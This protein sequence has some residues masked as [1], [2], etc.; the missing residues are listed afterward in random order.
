MKKRIIALLCLLAMAV[1][2]VATGCQ[3]KVVAYKRGEPLPVNRINF[4]GLD[5]NEFY[6]AG[7][8]GPQNFYAAVG[9]ALPS[10]LTDE[11]YAKLAE[12]GIN[13]IIEQR[14]DVEESPEAVKALELAEKYNINYFMKVE[15][16]FKTEVSSPADG[17]IAEKE[18]IKTKLEELLKYD[19]FGGVYFRDEPCSDLFPFL[20]DAVDVLYEVREELDDTTLNAYI[21]GFPMIGWSGLSNG[22]DPEM[23]WEKY[24][25]GI[26]ETGVDYLSWDAYPF[27]N[28]PGE[29]QAT[30]LNALGTMKEIGDR[31]NLPIIGNVQCGGYLP[32]F[33]TSH[34]VVNE[35]EM[36]WNVGTM[37]AF[38]FKGITYYTLVTPPEGALEGEEYVNND[39]ILNK[40]GTKTPFW[41]YAKSINEQIQAMA[42]VLLNATQEGVMLDNNDS[43]NIYTGKDILDSYR[44]LKGWSGDSA[45]IGCFDYEGTV[46]LVVVNNSLE[47]RHAVV[48]LEFDNNYEYEVTQRATIDTISG[49]EFSLHLDSGEFALV[50]V[51]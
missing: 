18:T 49:K 33:S 48:T 41:H 35:A 31:Y 16:V 43:P 12:A 27:T 38:G 40:Y 25:E 5:E 32:F 8:I 7:Y 3:G 6:I 50:V 14:M 24:L 44:C 42:P 47:N 39:S 15:S 20:T 21:N 36:N 19:S 4:R 10:L 23:T 11:V 1:S 28:V 9:Y 2:L 46:A 26:C 13:Y 51:K 29:V 30:W 17:Y 34:R 22:T 45:L 37:L